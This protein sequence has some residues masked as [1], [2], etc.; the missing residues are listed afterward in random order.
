MNHTKPI[1]IAG[2]I[3]GRHRHI[4]V[5]FSSKEEY[6][7]LLSFI[8]EGLERGERVCQIV[9]GHWH[10]EHVRRLEEA[11]IDVAEAQRAE[12]ME[13]QHWEEAYLQE[14]YLDC[15]RQL[16]L[17]E[18]MLVTGR[19]KRFSGTRLRVVPSGQSWIARCSRPD[20]I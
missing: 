14:G 5:L 3:L 1:R 6:R 16:S 19:S 4:Y 11:G 20:R 17:I 13:L 18:T 15:H 9:D 12:R 8:K 7:V 2:S 10:A